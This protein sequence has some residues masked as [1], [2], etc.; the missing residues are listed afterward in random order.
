M[1]VTIRYDLRGAHEA[2]WQGHP[3][4]VIEALGL[5]ILKWSSEPIADAIFMQ[6]DKLPIPKPGFIKLSSYTFPYGDS[7]PPYCHTQP[8]DLEFVEKCIN[9]L[10]S[11]AMDNQDHCQA[12]FDVSQS[13]T[14]LPD[15]S[16]GWMQHCEGN[17]TVTLIIRERR[18]PQFYID[19]F[20]KENG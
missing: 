8:L 15:T 3:S 19:S 2:G 17:R 10:R 6:V 11:F 20:N 5:T 9:S 16:E 7:L 18:S 14:R 4:T 12:S 13:P 1:S